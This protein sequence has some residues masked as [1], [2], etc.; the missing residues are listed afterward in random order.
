[1]NQKML[2][3]E[4]V[5]IIR[6]YHCLNQEIIPSDCI[7]GIWSH[8]LHVAE[9]SSELFLSGYWESIIFTGGL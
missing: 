4:S 7:I 2:D 6:D 8:D 3:Y 5:K 1:M 9:R